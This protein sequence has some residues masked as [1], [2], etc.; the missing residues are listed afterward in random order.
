MS[1]VLLKDLQNEIGYGRAIAI[2]GAG[3][4]VGSSRGHELASWAGLLKNGI[5]RCV[6]CGY[7]VPPAKWDVWQRAAIDDGD[8]L[9]WLGVAE[10]VER[11]LRANNE[12]PRWVRE[13][14]G[15][16]RAG[17]REVLEA[18][19]DLGIPIA[20]TN[21]DDLLEEVTG[22]EPVTLRDP[23]RALRVLRKEE[24]GILHLHGHWGTPESLVLGI[25]SYENHIGNSRVAALQHALLDYNTVV[26]VGFGAGLGDPNF[27]KLREWLRV[28]GHE[29][30]HYRL[31]L[32]QELDAPHVRTQQGDRIFPIAFGP[33]HAHLAPFLRSLR[34]TTSIGRAAASVRQGTLLA[35]PNIDDL[36]HCFGRD[37]VI[38]RL[39][40]A[41]IPR[42]AGGAALVYGGPGFGKTTVT[43]NVA[44]HPDIIDRFGV[45]RWFVKLETVQ[46]A[47]GII[48]AV[49]FAIGL[50]VKAGKGA[51][52]AEL[53]SKFS[54]L[55]LDN[56][57]TPWHADRVAVTSILSELR[58]ESN[59]AFIASMRGDEPPTEL[60]WD[61]SIKLGVLDAPTSKEIFLAIAENIN[62]TDPNLDF[63]LDWAAGIPLAINLIATC[64][65]GY[66]SLE[67]LRQD[68]NRYGPKLIMHKNNRGTHRRDLD[69]CIE[70]SLKS[71]LLTRPGRRLFSLL[72]KLPAG[73]GLDDASALLGKDAPFAPRQLRLVGLLSEREGRLD[74]LPPIRQV[75]SGY[76]H[77]SNDRR[78]IT[79]YTAFARQQSRLVGKE[80]NASAL[81]CLTEELPNV[82][83]ALLCLALDS[84]GRAEA[85]ALLV[86]GLSEA[87][88]ATKFAAG[89]LSL[90][91]SL[92]LHCRRD[93]DSTGEAACLIA[94]AHS[95]HR[96]SDDRLARLGF[97]HA[98]EL[99]R[100]TRD[101]RLLAECFLGFARIAMAEGSFDEARAQFSQSLKLSEQTGW[102]K[103]QADCLW[104]LA[105]F[106]REQSRW[107]E[108]HNYYE[109]ACERYKRDGWLWGEAAC[110]W[111][112]AEVSRR[113]HRVGDARS[114]YAQAGELY[115]RA[116]WL[117]GRAFCV[118]GL[119][120]L[121]E[122]AGER[123]EACDRYA[124]AEALFRKTW[125]AERADE[126]GCKLRELG[127]QKR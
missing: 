106:A 116:G 17:D 64:A 89:P 105:E 44:V 14:V 5:A 83:A 66:S 60:C 15:S 82:E 94:Q 54:L 34:P 84:K 3:V 65:L 36:G 124:M 59:L 97:D 121:A 127:G 77:S 114:L 76:R 35:R 19:R 29:H 86:E 73:I 51:V 58:A 2:V 123:E 107:D 32:D 53:G 104:D 87:I 52:L 98:Q 69:V 24:P 49:A 72:G 47:T 122:T 41:L 13:T 70:C 95:A 43:E 45:R 125:F 112:L 37:A 1:S 25:V 113:Q 75:A 10:Q 80:G 78:W 26:F 61:A 23:N 81:A 88:L 109:Q 68:W 71:P 8:I 28:Q 93:H 85:V 22:L 20:T 118:M 50:E 117:A 21:Y 4:S 63:F 9:D 57:E 27:E 39:V 92:A 18:I 62:K 38:R 101:D 102:L 12:Y 119:A 74:L 46:T 42:A 55:V 40:G 48:E 91:E 90:F 108:A 96:R 126:A 11:R 103:G 6:E 100:E 111:G 56:L 110:L 33:T 79:H 30:R 115:D 120:A 99:L 16:L 31:C 7:P 67:G